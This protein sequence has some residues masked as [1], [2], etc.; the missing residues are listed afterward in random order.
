MGVINFFPGHI[1]KTYDELAL[2]LKKTDLVVYILDARIPNY[3]FNK[4]I[5]DKI[6]HKNILVVLNKINYADAKL[7]DDFINSY[8][9]LTIIKGDLKNSKQD[10]ENVKKHIYLKTKTIRDAKT[11]KGIVIPIINC[12]VLGIPNVG[13]STLINMLAKLKKTKVENISGTTKRIDRFEINDNLFVYDTPGILW[14]KLAPNVGEA[15]VATGSIKEFPDTIEQ[16]IHFLL[17]TLYTKYYNQLTNVLF[18]PNLDSFDIG[19]ILIYVAKINGCL[20]G[21]DSYDD[22]RVYH[23]L[24][25]KIRTGAIKGINLEL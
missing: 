4:F 6:N 11:A 25:K 24:L 7:V 19:A 20:K 2:V 5:M 14:P 17:K 21:N 23:L 15:L 18:P 8:S 1:K 16:T 9:E 3:S 10:L 13:K 22:E 12:L